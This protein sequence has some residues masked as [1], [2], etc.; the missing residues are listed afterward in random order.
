MPR[1]TKS[2]KRAEVEAE[3]ARGVDF[4]T[5]SKKH[6]VPLG[7]LKTWHHKYGWAKKREEYAQK[8]SDALFNRLVDNTSKA[9]E[10]YL[11]CSL[12]IGEIGYQNLNDI[13]SNR[14]PRNSKQVMQIKEWAKVLKDGS[15]LIKNV[16]PEA[17]EIQ[18]EEMLKQ[19]Q[20]LNNG[21]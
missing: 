15:S 10:R 21:N 2:E 1:F 12:I 14:E 11:A 16:V 17:N 20:G 6:N 3:F 13:L 8:F 7:T 18:V 19:L 5:L 4:P 9:A